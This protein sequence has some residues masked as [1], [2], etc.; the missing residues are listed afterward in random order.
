VRVLVIRA[1]GCMVPQQSAS[2]GKMKMKI[3]AY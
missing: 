3:D 1:S 2:I